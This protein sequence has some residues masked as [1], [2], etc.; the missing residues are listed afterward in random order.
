M[1]WPS[2]AFSSWWALQLVGHGWETTWP[3]KGHAGL[4]GVAI[5]HVL[6]DERGAARSFHAYAI[7]GSDH[8]AVVA[9]LTIPGR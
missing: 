3:E 9:D 8:K 4:P 7:R 5:D 2:S 6:I 1:P